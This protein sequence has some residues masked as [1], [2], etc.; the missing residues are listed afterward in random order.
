MRRQILVPNRPTKRPYRDS[1]VSDSLNSLLHLAGEG[2]GVSWH[3]MTVWIDRVFAKAEVKRRRW[4]FRRVRQWPKSTRWRALAEPDL[5]AVLPKKFQQ[6]Q[7]RPR[8]ALTQVEDIHRHNA[9]INRQ[10]AYAN[11]RGYLA[12][13]AK[14]RIEVYA[15]FATLENPLGPR[16]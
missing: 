12:F 9:R 10:P 2:S 16:K 6:R 11:L 13:E 1:R 15:L 3:V 8:S 7:M 5:V 4:Q 14:N